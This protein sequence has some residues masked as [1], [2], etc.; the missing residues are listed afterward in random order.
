MFPILSFVPAF[1]FPH[2]IW[3][4]QRCRFWQFHLSAL[5]FVTH[6]ANLTVV[7]TCEKQ[8]MIEKY[9]VIYMFIL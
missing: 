5:L 2:E 8:K 9:S 7:H 6:I 4:V 3:Y 1:T